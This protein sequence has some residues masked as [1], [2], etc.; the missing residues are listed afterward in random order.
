MNG[1]CALTYVYIFI[2]KHSVIIQE[3]IF[4]LAIG[5]M[6]VIDLRISEARLYS[7][8]RASTDNSR[9]EGRPGGK[10]KFTYESTPAISEVKLGNMEE[11]APERVRVM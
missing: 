8:P 3:L 11:T 2:A 1:E 6:N 10:G 4:L 9:G 5:N 7:L